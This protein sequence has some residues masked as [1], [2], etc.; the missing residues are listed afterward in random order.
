M[1]HW[2]TKILG[3]GLF[4]FAVITA[5]LESL[6]FYDLIESHLPSWLLPMIKPEHTLILALVGILVFFADR[7][8]NL[9]NDMQIKKDSRSSEPLQVATQTGNPAVTQTANPVIDA[10][11]KVEIHNYPN[12]P[13]TS[14]TPKRSLPERP[15]HNVEFLG[16]R[17]I[18]T[19]LEAEIDDDGDGVIAVKACF[20]NRSKP[21]IKIADFDYA[22]ARI[23]FKNS[24][25]LEV[26]DISKV[27]WLG[28]GTKDTVHIA[29]NTKECV[30][31]A[32]YGSG[33]KRWAAPFLAAR[34]AGYW[35]HGE[36]QLGIDAK[37]LPN[38]ELS[39]EITLVGDENIGLHPVVVHM[40]L[41]SNGEVS[42]AP[43]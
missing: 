18:K 1:F 12:F 32:M 37:S 6:H 31:L 39:V 42:I 8:H 41:G 29:V 17:K 25:G 33:E 2:I 14:Q 19:N 23:V 34:P 10:S 7:V 16:A 28:H 27:L 11:Q 35:E 5:A 3:S 38:E 13:K 24:L 20:L 36:T 21:G 22:R 9:G 40:T 43:H 26:A 30:L 4:L 15:E